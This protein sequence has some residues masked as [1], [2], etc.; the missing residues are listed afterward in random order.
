VH[1]VEDLPKLGAPREPGKGVPHR[2][3]RRR[4]NGGAT[5]IDADRIDGTD[6]L[7]HQFDDPLLERMGRIEVG[8][9]IPTRGHRGGQHGGV[10]PGTVVPDTAGPGGSAGD[11]PTLGGPGQRPTGRVAERVCVQAGAG[12]DGLDQSDVDGFSVVTRA[13]HSNL[14]SD[15]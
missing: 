5:S 3:G 8:G 9:G 2:K 7:G 13:R 6:Q 11:Q 10:L 4:Q 1:G 15:H 14:F 12:Q